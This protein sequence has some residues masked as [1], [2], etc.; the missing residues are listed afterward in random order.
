MVADGS[1]GPLFASDVAVDDGRIVAVERGLAADV[2]DIVLDAR[3]R[4]V[5]PGFIGL[6]TVRIARMGEDAFT[7]E[8]TADEIDAMCW[9]VDRA[10]AAGAAG[11]ATKTLP[12]SRP[13]PSQFASAGETEALLQVLGRR[14]RGIAMFN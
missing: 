2:A 8:A 13:S 4:V 6:S 5:A 11:F 9:L 10:L 1:G 7:R 12:G 3:E 14:G